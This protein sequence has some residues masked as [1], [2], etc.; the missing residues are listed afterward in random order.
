MILKY[1]QSERCGSCPSVLRSI[2]K[3]PIW[4]PHSFRSRVGIGGAEAKIQRVPVAS[5]CSSRG[6]TA[7]EQHEKSAPWRMA[8]HSLLWLLWSDGENPDSKNCAEGKIYRKI[9]S[10]RVSPEIWGVNWSR[11]FF[12]RTESFLGQKCQNPEAQCV[13][14][15]SSVSIRTRWARIE[16]EGNQP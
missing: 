1:L 15:S 3:N 4:I 14:D 13:S 9:W 7:R 10:F 2:S 11:H 16:L 6:C 5:R 8:V 12:W